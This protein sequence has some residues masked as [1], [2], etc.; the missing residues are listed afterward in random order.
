[1]E[2]RGIYNASISCPNANWNGT[3]TN[4]CTNV[5]SDDVVAHEWGHAYTEFGPGL[6]YAWQA[7]A[8][9]ESYSDIWGEVVD[10]LNA[11]EDSG[12]DLSLRTGCGTSLRWM[13]GEDA[14][15]FGGA[16]RDM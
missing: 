3:T 1:A 11:Y 5:A 7:G 14:S 13:M 16:I 8:L 2:M 9:N 15:A 10:L 6:I 12:E 4:F